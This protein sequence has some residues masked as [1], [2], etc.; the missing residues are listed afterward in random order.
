LGGWVYA[1]VVNK[2]IDILKTAGEKIH[3]S[4]LDNNVQDLGG[5]LCN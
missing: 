5:N 4:P 2:V 1:L 3:T